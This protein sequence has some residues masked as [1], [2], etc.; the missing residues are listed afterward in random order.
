MT[1]ATIHE[2]SPRA[3]DWLRVFGRLTD[4]PL[5]GPFVIRV[6]VPGRSNVRA[7][8]LDIAALDPEERLRLVN[9][10]ATR[11]NIPPAEVDR[12]LDAEG[13]PILAED[14]LVSIPQGL[15]LSMMGGDD[16]FDLED[17]EVDWDD[18]NCGWDG[19]DDDD[20]F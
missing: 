13:V 4:I 5:R 11:F 17:E 6:N 7:Y 2:T 3:S 19:E 15:A 9:H 20:Y 12:D 8:L 14:V 10:I 18:D 16:P 1:T